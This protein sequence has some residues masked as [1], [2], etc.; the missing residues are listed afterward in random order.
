VRALHEWIRTGGITN[1]QV[2]RGVSRHGRVSER[3]LTPTGVALLGKNAQSPRNS[4]PPSTPATAYER[5]SPHL[6]RSA[7]RPNGRL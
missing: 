6:V 3:A 5:G 1:G 7:V 2:F 4:I